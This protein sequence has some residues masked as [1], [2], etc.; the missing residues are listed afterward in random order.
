MTVVALGTITLR[1]GDGVKGL[2]IEVTKE[3]LQAMGNLLYRQVSVV[4]DGGLEHVRTK[5]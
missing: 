3:E 5:S 2:A 4:P 1:T